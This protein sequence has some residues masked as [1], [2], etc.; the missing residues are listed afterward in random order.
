[1]A[2]EPD[3]DGTPRRVDDL[4]AAIGLLN[5]ARYSLI[6]WC[7]IGAVTYYVW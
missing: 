1:M 3:E 4:D 5:A 2:I 7:I 6:L